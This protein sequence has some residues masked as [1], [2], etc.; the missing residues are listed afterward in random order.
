MTVNDIYKKFVRKQ[1][2]IPFS[3]F[4][5]V[6]N[7]KYSKLEN[8][9][10][11]SF[12]DW[13]NYKYSKLGSKAWFNADT[14]QYLS[15]LG[16]N[17]ADNADKTEVEKI[18]DAVSAGATL[19]DTLKSTGLF[20]SKKKKAA[21]IAANTPVVHNTPKPYIKPKKSSKF[22]VWGYILI[23]IVVVGGAGFTAYKMNKK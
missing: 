22:P 5:E 18:G 4:I 9:N 17:N 1:V 13:I 7:R 20:T 21:Q 15:D 16:Y 6:E 10:K 8:E 23:G 12:I 19:V 3:D 11:P 14:K 2:L